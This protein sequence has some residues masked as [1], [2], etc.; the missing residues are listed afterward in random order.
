MEKK[1]IAVPAAG[2]LS[3]AGG[4]VAGRR[5]VDQ[6]RK[7]PGPLGGHPVRFPESATEVVVLADGAEIATYRI[8]SG[9]TVVVVHGLTAS[10]HD[11][12][13]IAAH[14]VEAGFEVLAIDQRGHGNSTSGR[15]GF[16]SRQLGNDL[17]QVFE[18]LDIQAVC[19]AGHSMGAMAAMGFAAVETRRFNER[20]QSF[21]SVASTGAT[22]TALQAAALRLGGIKIPKRLSQIAAN[23]LRVIAGLSVF[24]KSPSLN[25]IDE[26]IAS[27]RKC[28]EPVRGAATKA[29]ADHD[30]LK[31][32]A[33]LEAPSLVIGAGRD[34]LIDIDQVQE[35]FQTLPNSRLTVYPDAGHMVIWERHVEVA[36]EIVEFVHSM[37]ESPIPTTS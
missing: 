2:I 30:V 4:L 5:L 25:M 10:H 9:P 18:T 24:G 21:V 16:G 19:L 7:N 11:W 20:V 28:P 14:L 37:V 35:L 32:L 8:G 33:T 17:S 27:F 26:A 34:R 6:W 12:G 36:A 3:L 13:P 15:A 31:E 1:T 22:D 23:R 29:L